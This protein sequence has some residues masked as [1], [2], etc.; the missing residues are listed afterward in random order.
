MDLSLH[1]QVVFAALMLGVALGMASVAFRFCT[2][3]AVSDWRLLGDTTRLRSWAL[4]AV[5]AALGLAVFETTGWIDLSGGSFPDYRRAPLPWGRALLGG[6][7]FGLGMS[8]ASGCVLR[9]LTRTGSGDLRALCVLLVVGAV[10]WWMHWGDG[11]ALAFAPWLGEWT[12]PAAWPTD[13]AALMTL[14]GVP[15]GES[16]RAAVLVLGGAAGLCV[17]RSAAFRTDREAQRA[18]LV[19]G[20]VVFALWYVTGGRVGTTWQDWAAMEFDVP[21][22]VAPQ[23]ATLVSPLAD[24]I[25]VLFV[26]PAGVTVGMAVAAGSLLGAALY[27]AGR[28]HWRLRGFAGITDALW[29]LFGAVL[30]GVGG[31]LAMGC[32]LGQGVSGVSTLAFASLLATVAMVAGASAGL[33]LRQRFD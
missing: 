29:H 25:Q 1:Q 33:A 31:V 21:L 24:L 19:V 18:A 30:M 14:A 27:A 10:A 32:S 20:G 15:E 9:N 4:A 13:A 2:L 12:F 17:F 28:G 22:H 26:Q 11:Y 7:L 3:G 6:A 16:R 5:V 8:L 23:S